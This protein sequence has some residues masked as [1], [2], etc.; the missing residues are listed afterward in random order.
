MK[1]IIKGVFC[2]F[3]GFVVNLLGGWD[4]WLSSLVFLMT[5]DIIVGLIKA[6]LCKSEKSV[7]GGLNSASMFK[8]G[9][10]KILI[11]FIIALA[12]ILD[13]IVVPDNTYIRCAVTGY[14]IANE[15]LSI[16]ENIGACGVPLP[17]IFY[18]ILDVLK[19]KGDK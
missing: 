5:A 6:F 19:Q 14:Y 9:L 17:K 18:S 15:G 11:F 1:G 13:T 16:L 3:G 12:T 7:S 4:I 10:K 8:G 2:I